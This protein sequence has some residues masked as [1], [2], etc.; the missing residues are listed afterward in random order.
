MSVI[1]LTNTQFE[2]ELESLDFD[3]EKSF[4]KSPIYLQL[5][6]LP[7]LYAK[8]EDLI[9]VTAFP[10]EKEWNR[11]TTLLKKQF[12][13]EAASL[14]LF[15]SCEK[16]TV[17][18]WGSSRSVAKWAKENNLFYQIPNW[19]VIR[20]INGKP[21]AFDQV[22][23]LP[24]SCLVHSMSELKKTVEQCSFPVILKSCFGVAARG[25]MIVE[26]VEVLHS[27]KIENFCHQQWSVGLSIILEPWLERSFDFSTHWT[28]SPK[29]TVIYEGW[30]PLE[31]TNKG[32]YVASIAGKDE[33]HWVEEQKE[34]VEPI[35][36][37]AAKKGFFGPVSVDAF[38]YD[39]KKVLHPVVEIN[40]RMTM[41][42]V[43]L[44]FQKRVCPKNVIRLL[45]VPIGKDQLQSLLPLSID[46]QKFSRQLIIEKM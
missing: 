11:V 3:L 45:Y 25:N 14:T 19:D 18:S 46:N 42:R 31:N 30:T 9:V 20:E 35:L 10:E 34:S 37:L 33:D 12:G 13:I 7:L 15:S 8:P 44:L 32:L 6:Y 1:H 39:S 43:A 40:A 4:E 23:K 36:S 16:G 2:Q 24:G 22:F 28:I 17:L 38:V 26:N 29:G 27:K 21:F 5:Q 41:S